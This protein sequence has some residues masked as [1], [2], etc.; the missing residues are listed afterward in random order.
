MQKSIK[1]FITV[2]LILSV[3]FSPIQTGY[4]Q[5]ISLPAEINKT[6][7]PIS[8]AAGPTPFFGSPFSIRTHFN[9]PTRAGPI[10]CLP[11]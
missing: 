2:A 1:P 10:I 4:A 11:A 6:F 3:L 9:W 7:T 8:I 5:G